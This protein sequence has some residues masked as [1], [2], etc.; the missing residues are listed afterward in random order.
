MSVSIVGASPHE[1]IPIMPGVALQK[2]CSDREYVKAANLLASG[3]EFTPYELGLCLEMLARE[4][5]ALDA[6]R[7]LGKA[8]RFADVRAPF[9]DRAFAQALSHDCNEIVDFFLHD[10]HLSK[11]LSSD[12]IFQGMMVSQNQQIMASLKKAFANIPECDQRTFLLEM[13]DS[14]RYDLLDGIA[15]PKF[16][17]E[18]VLA[19]ARKKPEGVLIKVLS[20]DWVRPI[21]TDHL[22]MAAAEMAMDLVKFT[23]LIKHPLYDKVEPLQIAAKLSAQKACF[24][25]EHRTDTQ[26]LSLKRIPEM[27]LFAQIFSEEVTLQPAIFFHF[28][29]EIWYRGLMAKISSGGN[30][31]VVQFFLRHPAVL[32]HLSN[33]H[34]EELFI[35]A[36]ETSD[37]HPNN[38]AVAKAILYGVLESE[39][40]RKDLEEADQKRI[41]ELEEMHSKFPDSVIVA[42][43]TLSVQKN[44]PHVLRVLVRTEQ[45]KKISKNVLLHY[46]KESAENG[47]IAV[48]K[49]LLASHNWMGQEDELFLCLI[50]EPSK[51][52]LEFYIEL[53][54]FDRVNPEYYKRVF[55][56]IFQSGRIRGADEDHSDAVRELRKNFPIIMAFQSMIFKILR[57]HEFSKLFPLNE[58]FHSA[59][60]AFAG[61]GFFTH[62]GQFAN[63]QLMPNPIHKLAAEQ[64]C[65]G[66]SFLVFYK[67]DREIGGKPI[68]L[69]G[70]IDQ[71]RKGAI[72]SHLLG[73]VWLFRDFRTQSTRTLI[74]HLFF[75]S[76]EMDSVIALEAI[77]DGCSGEYRPATI[78][79]AILIAERNKNRKMKALL[80]PPDSCI[81]S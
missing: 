61:M 41:A 48:A 13:A 20:L 49:E 74:D 56:P 71:G 52:L 42:A 64:A 21:S 81:V 17:G 65:S 22:A 16:L 79:Q 76:A 29:P 59:Y 53:P 72:L 8:K 15:N 68:L 58:K 3:E 24:L 14:A 75:L 67:T 1:M 43:V 40:G 28:D 78:A 50:E 31:F 37:V 62:I 80:C 30:E 39:R 25:W 2:A 55:E 46:L 57:A 66:N 10:G 18:I 38:W 19:V 27:V 33:Q 7:E 60:L 34:R 11:E 69:P 35:L 9:I 12:A 36:C 32:T 77:L 73:S 70:P 26:D 6:I 5:Q 4:N 47:K 44:L 23:A 63:H 45:Y 54:C 51:D